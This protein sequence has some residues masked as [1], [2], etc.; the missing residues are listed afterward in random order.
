[1]VVIFLE[2]G[3]MSLN[4]VMGVIIYILNKDYNGKDS[5]IYI[6]EDMEVS[7]LNILIVLIIINVVNDV[8]IV[9]GDEIII[10]ED[11]VVEIDVVVNDKDIDSNDVID[12]LIFEVVI[13]FENG[14]VKVSNELIIYIL[15]VNFSGS[16]LFIYCIVDKVGVFFKS[17]IVLIIIGEINDV[18]VVSVD[19]FELNEDIFMIFFILDNDVDVDSELLVKNVIVIKD[20]SYGVLNID[21]ELG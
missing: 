18:L 17:V 5:F 16:D 21:S 7:C 10:D 12:L 6:V 2:Y 14:D 15:K 4:I 11:M 19:M 3:K 1:M 20:L 9:L 8:L 13:L